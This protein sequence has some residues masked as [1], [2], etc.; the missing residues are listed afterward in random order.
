MQAEVQQQLLQELAAATG[1]PDPVVHD[2]P[3]L[4]ADACCHGCLEFHSWAQ[5]NFQSTDGRFLC[6]PCQEQAASESRSWR[7]R[8]L[9]VLRLPFF[10]VLASAALAMV[11]YAAGWG[12]PS[13]ASLRARDQGRPPH[14]QKFGRLL[15][16]QVARVQLRLEVLE[17]GGR[18]EEGVRWAALGRGALE[19]LAAADCWGGTPVAPD[20]ALAAAVMRSREGDTAKALADLTALEPHYPPDSDARLSYLYQ[21]G[22][23]ALRHNGLRQCRQDWETVLAQAVK[24][25]NLLAGL[26]LL[27]DLIDAAGGQQNDLAWRQ[28]VRQVCGADLPDGY[29]LTK[30]LRQFKAH[31]IKSEVGERVLDQ[32]GGIPLLEGEEKPPAGADDQFFEK[33][34]D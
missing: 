32:L 2:D 14:E 26:S 13:V 8:S 31:G 33:F 11:L 15:L 12:N 10:Y 23:A 18:E 4:A 20:L 21:R 5:L 7:A 3:G 28:G 27:D 19:Q 9:A 29:M 22:A 34:D 1:Q 24:P 25:R 30:I 6:R 17:T 16:Q